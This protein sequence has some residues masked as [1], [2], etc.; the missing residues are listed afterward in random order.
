MK[1]A[2]RKRL[3]YLAEWLG[4][5][6]LVFVAFWQFAPVDWITWVI[7]F[8][9]AI[10]V[11]L[12]VNAFSGDEARLRSMLKRRT[13]I[14]DPSRRISVQKAPRKVEGRFDI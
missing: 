6:A 2:L 14:E 10:V 1:Y 4:I 5:W 8:T 12:M 7:G 3:E 11:L 9:A 13:E